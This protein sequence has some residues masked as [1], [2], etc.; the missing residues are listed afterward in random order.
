MEQKPLF[1]GLH[2]NQSNFEVAKRENSVIFLEED[3]D[4]TY[5]GFDPNS[6]GILYWNDDHAGGIPGP[7][8]YAGRFCSEKIYQ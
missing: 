5:G 3:Y 7:E 8:Y 2:R 6:P 1:L 4:I